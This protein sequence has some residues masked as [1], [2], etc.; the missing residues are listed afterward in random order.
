[1]EILSPERALVKETHGLF[2]CIKSNVQAVVLNALPV[3]RKCPLCPSGL[4][5]VRNAPQM[6]E[7]GLPGF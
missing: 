4:S 2:L 6:G 7:V 1:M 3:D 5:N